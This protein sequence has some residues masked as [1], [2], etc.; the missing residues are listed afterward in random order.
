MLWTHASVVVPQFTHKTLANLQVPCTFDFNVAATKYFW[1]LEQGELPLVFL[2]S[3]SVFYESALGNLQVAPIS[4][5][6]EAGFRLPV[7][8]WHQLMES[9]YPNGAWLRIRKDVFDRLHQYK[10]Q[11]GTATWEDALE[12][13]L[14]SVEDTVRS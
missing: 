5:D 7:Q 9:Y 8:T 3:G 4:W 12:R 1:G 14:A 6:K 10:M 11:C 2:F 13:L